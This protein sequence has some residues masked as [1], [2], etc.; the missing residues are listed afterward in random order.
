MSHPPVKA[1]PSGETTGER[2]LTARS[3]AVTFG[4]TLRTLSNW[5]RRG[6]LIPIRHAGLRYYRVSEVRELWLTSN[7]IVL[8][9]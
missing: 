5:E 2:L 3:V 8:D 4:R 1:P 6:L 7:N 9:Q